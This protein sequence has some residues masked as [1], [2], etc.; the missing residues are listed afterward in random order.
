MRYRNKL[1]I[2]IIIIIIIIDV[3]FRRRTVCRVKVKF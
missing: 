3:W 2:I 1:F